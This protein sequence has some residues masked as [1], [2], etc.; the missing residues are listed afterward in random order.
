MRRSQG[1]RAKRAVYLSDAE[2]HNL[3]L[4]AFPK[5]GPES[6]LSSRKETKR[7]QPESLRDES[8]EELAGAI[9]KWLWCLLFGAALGVALAWWLY[10]PVARFFSK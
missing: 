2:L 10:E 1:K 5:D 8:G 4:H 6:Y 9:L 3:H 7:S